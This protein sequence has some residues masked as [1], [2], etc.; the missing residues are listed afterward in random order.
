MARK[1]TKVATESP[2]EQGGQYRKEGRFEEAEHAFRLAVALKHDDEQAWAELG[3]LLHEDLQR[4]DEAEQAYRKAIKLD[5]EY[6]W[7]WAKFGQLLNEKL[8]RP[9]A[10]EEAYGGRSSWIRTMAGTGRTLAICCTE[11]FAAMTRLRRPIERRSSLT[12]GTLGPGPN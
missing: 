4:Y 2:L 12:P 3:Q 5:P 9:D 1:T 11:S 6:E 10:A 8:E 7:A